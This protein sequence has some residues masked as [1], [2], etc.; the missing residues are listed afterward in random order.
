MKAGY[1]KRSAKKRLQRAEWDK[2]VIIIDDKWR[3]ARFDEK[4]WVVEFKGDFFGYFGSILTAFQSLPAKMLSAEARDSIAE[5]HRAQQEI[6]ERIL[7]ALWHA[8]L[9]NCRGGES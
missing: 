5:V 7:K 9:S 4:N 6:N 8:V 3:I 2:Q 1:E